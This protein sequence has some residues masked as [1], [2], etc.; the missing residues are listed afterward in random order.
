[1]SSYHFIVKLGGSVKKTLTIKIWVRRLESFGERKRAAPSLVSERGGKCW[2]GGDS[3]RN[4]FKMLF[5][6]IFFV[7][8]LMLVLNC[9]MRARVTRS[10][11]RK[12]SAPEHFVPHLGRRARH[13]EFTLARVEKVKSVLNQSAIFARE[14]SGVKLGL[15]HWQIHLIN[16]AV[17]LAA[18][19][20]FHERD[21]VDFFVSRKVYF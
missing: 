19:G 3:R 2:H 11:G 5:S 7:L 20:E 12:Q 16:F 6:H 4:K 17:K 8:R 18:F 15:R 10:F 9:A 1:M 13:Y 14:G 21:N